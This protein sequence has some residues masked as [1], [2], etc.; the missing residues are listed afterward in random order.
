MGQGTDTCADRPTEVSVIRF[1]SRNRTIEE[2][3]PKKEIYTCKQRGCGKIFTNQ[4]EY[5][6]HEA[7]EALKIRFICREP[8]CGEEL[9]DPGSMWRHYQEWHNNETNVFIC[10]YTNCGSLHT[11]SSNLEEHIESCHRQ[12]PTLPTEPEVIC[13]EDSENAMDE[14]IVQSTEDCYEKRSNESFAVKRH[15]YMDNNE[16]SILRNENMQQHKKD[17]SN[18]QSISNDSSNKEDYASTT[19]S[20][21][22]SGGFCATENLILNTENFLSKYEGNTKTCSSELQVEHSQEKI[23]VVYVNGDIT[24]TKNSK[25]ELYN[26]N[27]RNQE[28][29]IELDN[30]E[31]IFRNDLDCDTSKNEEYTIETNSNCSDDEEYTPKKQRMSRYK[32]EIY[33][34]EINGCGRKYKYISHYR[35]HQESHKL[36]ANTINSN[37]SKSLMKLKQGKAS[38]VSF[39]LCKIP[40]CGAQVSNVT[41][42]WKHYQDNHANSK[43]LVQGTKSNEVFRCKIPGCEQEFSTTVML[44]KHFSEVHSNGS[45]NNANTNTKTGN[46]SSFHYTEIFKD[47]ATS[48]QANFKTDFKTKHNINVNDCTKNTDEQ[49]LSSIVKNESR[50]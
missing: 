24:I 50:D 12:L 20:L 31:R 30:L 32:Q 46:G 48:P 5:K 3:A 43:L 28:H 13:F 38:T 10:P 11:T 15:Q 25:H 39:F 17:T 4:D 7:L 21:K 36:V 27:S 49:R 34:C 29:R 44:Y 23:N 1:V 42:L 47:D 35:H 6:T 45:G 18:D 8:G 26:M 41:G 14:E 33:K 40:G 19:E 9:S 37:S 22:E 2:I 16:Q